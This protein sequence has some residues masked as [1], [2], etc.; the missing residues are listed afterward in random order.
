[1]F[2]KSGSF[3]EGEPGPGPR[4]SLHQQFQQASLAAAISLAQPPVT[5][6]YPQIPPPAKR[7]RKDVL[8]LD[9]DDQSM[10][11]LSGETQQPAQ[12]FSNGSRVVEG[13][14]MED[15]YK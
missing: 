7:Q 11:G 9:Q 14:S 2:K 4:I 12:G 15:G 8:G 13:E 1:M 6:P 10:S 3:S 5:N